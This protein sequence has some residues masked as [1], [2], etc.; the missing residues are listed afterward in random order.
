M[1]AS[2]AALANAAS[3]SVLGRVFARTLRPGIRLHA[4]VVCCA[5]QASRR[6]DNQAPHV[7]WR[8]SEQFPSRQGECGTNKSTL[9]HARLASLSRSVPSHCRLL[10]R[11]SNDLRRFKQEQIWSNA[12]GSAE[13]P[14]RSAHSPARAASTCGRFQGVAQQFPAACL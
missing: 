2:S 9:L 8:H 12:F 1:P 5:R 14:S 11:P 10:F 3:A 4:R 7:C 13:K 6:S